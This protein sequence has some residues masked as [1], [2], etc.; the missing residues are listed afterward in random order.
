MPLIFRIHPGQSIEDLPKV[1][2][3]RWRAMQTKSGDVHLVGYALET[4]RG[5]VST[6]VQSLDPQARTAITA[7]G[8]VYTLEG[9]PGHEPMVVKLW[10][11]W[12]RLYGIQHWRDVTDEIAKNL[13]TPTTHDGSAEGLRS[14]PDVGPDEDSECRDSTEE[15]P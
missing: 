1:A 8:R 7:S 10:V 15:S 12:A 5:R 4:A 11:G 13:D 6:P 14:T 2:L 9:A 3:I